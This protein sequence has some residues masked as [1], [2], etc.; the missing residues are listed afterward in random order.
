M[1]GGFFKCVSYCTK[2]DNDAL[3]H[4]VNLLALAKATKS[5]KKEIA[6]QVFEK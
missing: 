6:V 2:E 4:N 3:C 1:K 5:K